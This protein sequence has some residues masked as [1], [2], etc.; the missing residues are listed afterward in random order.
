MLHVVTVR[1]V[2]LRQRP[3]QAPQDTLWKSRTR[4]LHH[5]SKE[6]EGLLEFVLCCTGYRI[7]ENP[8][9]CEMPC[10]HKWISDYIG[11]Y[12]SIHVVSGS[13][14]RHLCYD[15]GRRW[16]I[17]LL[18]PRQW[19]RQKPF[20]RS[21]VFHDPQRQDHQNSLLLDH[22]RD[23]LQLKLPRVAEF[24]AFYNTI[25]QVIYAPKQW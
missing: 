1:P 12:P 21:S 14:L 13:P 22:S 6:Y 10:R 7:P 16:G 3:Q 19:G 9:C 18:H 17:M 24:A 2:G 20:H 15:K 23:S 4:T 25:V 5:P 11:M 8:W